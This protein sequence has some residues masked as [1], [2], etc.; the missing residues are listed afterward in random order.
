M[1]GHKNGVGVAR[2]IVDDDGLSGVS[3]F[4]RQSGFQFV[5]FSYFFQILA[6]ESGEAAQIVRDRGRSGEVWKAVERS[7]RMIAPEK[8]QL[9]AFLG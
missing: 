1:G 7:E 8:F 6:S 4:D 3:L 5:L 9:L 2:L